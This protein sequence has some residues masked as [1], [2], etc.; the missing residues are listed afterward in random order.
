M[1]KTLLTEAALIDLVASLNESF[2]GIADIMII[3]KNRIKLGEHIELF[4]RV[5]DMIAEDLSI[6]TSPLSA[7]AQPPNLDAAAQ[8]AKKLELQAQ[9]QKEKDNA[10]SIIAAA[11]IGASSSVAKTANPILAKANQQKVVGALKN[12]LGKTPVAGQQAQIMA[13]QINK[14]SI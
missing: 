1:A 12:L 11:R 3:K 8:T 13:T 9:K 10:K 14:P 4:I 7:S 5:D 6:P 2:P